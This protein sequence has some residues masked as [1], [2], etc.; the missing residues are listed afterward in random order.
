MLRGGSSG[1]LVTLGCFDFH[2]KSCKG[3]HTADMVTVLLM[4]FA[5]DYLPSRWRRDT[6]CSPAW[7]VSRYA[8]FP[9]E[10]QF[11]SIASIILIL[12]FGSDLASHDLL[13]THCHL[14]HSLSSFY[15]FKPVF[16]A[17]LISFLSPPHCVLFIH[18]CSTSHLRLFIFLSCCVPFFFSF[19]S[20]CMCKST[21]GCCSWNLM[22]F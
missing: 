3:Q 10:F 16:S 12:S 1:S 4:G 20:L 6:C 13:F 2:S 18:F 17:L 5:P 22:S 7:C 11:R 9:P 8:I 15:T 14:C 19:F 21:L